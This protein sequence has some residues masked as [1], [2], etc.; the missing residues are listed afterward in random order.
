L[1][2]AGL[3]GAQSPAANSGVVSGV[4]LGETGTPVG[5]AL[6]TLRRSG[7]TTRVG[8]SF[9]AADGTFPVEAVAPGSYRL[10]V[11]HFG[12][13]SAT[14]IEVNITRAAE[15]VDVGTIRLE[16]SVVVLEGV[17]VS[18]ARAPVT[19]LPDRNVYSVNDIPAAAGGTASDALRSVPELEVSVEGA[20]TTRG[21]TP[22]I[23][24]NGRPAAMQ[25]EA[26][27]RY[28]Q[29]LPAE[30]I[31]RIEV[32]SNPSARYEA[33]G[34]G[35][36]VNIVMKEGAGL[37]LSG[38]V[39]LNAGTR[40]QRGGSGS[41]NY[42]VGRLT[43]F[44]VASTS[45]FG[46]KSEGSDLRQN[47]SAH[48]ATYV[49]QDS[50]SRTS[51]G[52]GSVDLTG[53]VKI[54]ERG[55]LWAEL[56]AARNSSDAENL[57]AYAL[58]DS[59]RSPTERYDRVE[60]GLLRGLS[61]NALVG[62]RDVL[63]PGRSE[64]AVEL[65]RG[66]VSEDDSDES[67][68][69]GLSLDGSP[70][71][72]P[73]ELML[74]GGGY[75]ARDLSLE[76]DLMRPWGESGRVEVGYRG[77][78]AHEANRFRTEVDSSAEA[79]ADHLSTGDFRYRETIHAGFVTA[80][81]EVGRFDVQLG[82]RA[83][84]ARTRTFLPL[85]GDTFRVTYRNVF[86]N[87]G[88]STGLGAGGRLRLSYSRRVDRPWTEILNPVT[89]TLDPLNL[90]V[91]NPHLLPRYTHS[92]NLAMSRTGQLGTLQL[93]P[94]YRRTVDS[95]DQVRSV[96]EAGV[97][98]VTWRNLATISAYGASMS[99]S[100][101]HLGPLSGFAS[102]SGYR[103]LR[104]ASNL[105][106]DFSGASTR[107]FASGALSVRASAALSGQGTVSYLP[108][109]RLPQGRI[110]PMVFSTV[111]ARL[112]LR[113]GR[114]S[115]NFSIVDPFDVQRFTFTTKDRTHVQTGSSNVSARRASISFSY[116]FGRPPESNRRTD[117]D[118][119]AGN[120]DTGPRIR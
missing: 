109:R 88:I 101:T 65:R 23:H 4:V 79:G 49:R 116:S 2:L 70:L 38:S 35:G 85:A 71:A 13:R 102:L 91:G 25:G 72:L 59:L 24:I 118:E 32:I 30:R 66:I 81:R 90:E 55:T 117:P 41:I 3:L 31:D 48:P 97:S 74:N 75:D 44:G 17:E 61:G 26:L 103:E 39:A 11:S 112:R 47:L 100:L 106:E 22:S 15:R 36:I 53:E 93:S 40:N 73:P 50:H 84:H 62:Y 29:Q 56:S 82:I 83:E 68:R 14:G 99:A 86:P 108:A 98:T 19:I 94:F 10:E 12:Y 33:E 52:F 92:F 58:L 80:S 60:D 96:D 77:S 111:G 9:T 110:S 115:I 27:Q 95:W 7:D 28:L 107:L 114:G 69:Y 51:G 76:A 67:G 105:E 20:V 87:A 57:T 64:W 89:P 18:A 1:L 43:L 21:A 113:G 37:G 104:D 119:E 8:G 42:E 120:E 63:E 45:Y 6:I 46:N 54:G 34:Q 5:S 16:R 78:S